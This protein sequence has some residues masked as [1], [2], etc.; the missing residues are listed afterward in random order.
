MSSNTNP[1]AP[2]TD[3]AR[4]ELTGEASRDVDE[5]GRA[6]LVS[7]MGSRIAKGRGA[8]GRGRRGVWI[9]SL[10]AVVAVAAA[11]LF[12]LLP[13][14]PMRFAVEGGTT[15]RSDHGLVVSEGD[16]EAVATF[17][18]GSVV[19]FA[20]GASGRIDDV[21]AKGARVVLA[22]GRVHLDIVHRAGTTW[23][24]EAG[25]YVVRVTGTEFD[26]E[27]SPT[28]GALSVVMQRG[29]VRAEGP[30]ASNGVTLEAGYELHASREGEVRIARTAEGPVAE[31]TSAR[32]E[33]EAP[34]PTASE[35]ALPAPSES[36]LSLAET[37]A[38]AAP[39]ASGRPTG[40]PDAKPRGA[41]WPELV[42]EGR[43]GEVVRAARERGLE[44]VAR[45][46]P[47]SD[48]VALGD[49][50]RYEK[51]SEA[52]RAT[53]E[54]ERKRFGTSSAGKTA[55]FLL[56]RMAE[57]SDG[58]P[59]RA[60]ALYDE[61]LAAGGPFSQ[62]ALGRKMMAV[63]RSRGEG[64]ARPVAQVYLDRYPEGSYAKVARAMLEAP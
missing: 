43:Y 58:D 16:R 33:P 56:G 54:A 41:S 52:A 36:A 30:F 9:G 26:V 11:L 60:I 32:R 51:D 15:Q 40:S 46:A 23:S 37:S 62:E 63:K 38:S 17:S 4:R 5:A 21:G 29:S 12:A 2:V 28:T 35:S 45:T 6:R 10:V 49:A 57:D 44:S 20:P 39:A 42:S 50:A 19:K 24:V 34:A 64:A 13:P 55:T 31:A 3:L 8:E 53:L 18:D 25:P 22:A 27:W 7:A 59:A 48:L 1:L 47:L 14:R 61:Y